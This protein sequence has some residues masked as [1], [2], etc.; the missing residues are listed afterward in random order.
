MRVSVAACSGR[1]LAVVE[2]DPSWRLG[3]VLR[4]VP[5]PEGASGR[6][7]RVLLGQAGP[8]RERGPCCCYS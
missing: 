1:Q 7:R 8:A 5:E 4:A 2:A 6:R 3:D